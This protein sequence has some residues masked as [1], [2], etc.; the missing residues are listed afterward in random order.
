MIKGNDLELEEARKLAVASLRIKKY[1]ETQLTV[2]LN[3]L[4]YWCLS[5]TFLN[6]LK[7]FK[8]AYLVCKKYGM[9]MRIQN[10]SYCFK[11]AI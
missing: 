6:S 5:L 9:C 3:T 2:Y 11:K 8:H 7:F 4:D 10:R 1:V